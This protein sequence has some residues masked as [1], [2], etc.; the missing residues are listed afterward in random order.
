MKYIGHSRPGPDMNKYGAWNRALQGHALF[1][2]GVP[3]PMAGITA[4]V[5]E[6]LR[7]YMGGHLTKKKTICK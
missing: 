1:A 4:P 3:A 7:P 2:G 5:K 6:R